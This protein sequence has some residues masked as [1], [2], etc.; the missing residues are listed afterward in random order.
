[1]SAESIELLLQGRCFLF[2]FLQEACYLADLGIQAGGYDYCPATALA[3]QGAGIHQ[4]ASFSQDSA[5]S[6][7]S[8]V[9]SS[10][11][12]N[13]LAS[14]VIRSPVLR[15]MMSPGTRS[16]ALILDS[17]PSRITLTS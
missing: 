14:A 3:D 13:S 9:S 17:T 7:A 6:G 10:K 5:V 1:M 8:E 11:A 12:S 15:S 2:N 4:V 16:L